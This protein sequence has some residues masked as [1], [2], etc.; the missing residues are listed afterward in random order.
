MNRR[1]RTLLLAL[2]FGIVA[3][4]AAHSQVVVVPTPQPTVTAEHEQWYLNGGPITYAGHLYYPAGAAIA[5]MPN[6]M[7][8]SGFYMGIPLYTRTTIEPYSIV[9]VPLAGGRMQPYQRPRTG[10]LTGTAGSEPNPLPVPPATVPPGGLTP[11]AA[12]APSATAL[13]V[14]RQMPRPA[15][16]EPV[17]APTPEPPASIGEIAQA[18]GT[19][20]RVPSRSSH[21]S[22]GGRPQGTN[23]IFIEY[24]GVRW[25][26]AGPPREID[27]SRLV[28]LPD[29]QGFD[30]WSLSGDGRTIYIPVTRGSALAV[31]YTR[32][33]KGVQI[34]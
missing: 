19:S 1:A 13:I 21:V 32:A 10:E 18:V 27:V 5:F 28:R 20:G 8:R 7:V 6:E 22:I 34:R 16:T 11:Q 15:V 25:Y 33:R 29:Y 2:A 17:P 30:V 14:P 24:R 9:Y 31:P 26:P 23:A 3:R 12:G 4:N